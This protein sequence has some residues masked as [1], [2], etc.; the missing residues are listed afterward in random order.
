MSGVVVGGAVAVAGTVVEVVVDGGCVVD[1]REV[2]R[3]RLGRLVV[4]A[5]A[6]VVVVVV[7]GGVDD[8]AGPA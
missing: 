8:C 4:V 7:G 3:P 5:G 2:E 1:D 6:G